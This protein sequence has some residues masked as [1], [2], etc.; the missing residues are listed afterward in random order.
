[1]V[2][3]MN[4]DF[5]SMRYSDDNR[6]REYPSL[7]SV[8]PA[9]GELETPSKSFRNLLRRIFEA[10]PSILHN[11]IDIGHYAVSQTNCILNKSQDTVYSLSVFFNNFAPRSSAPYQSCG[12]T[13]GADMFVQYLTTSPPCQIEAAVRYILGTLDVLAEC[14][15]DRTNEQLGHPEDLPNLSHEDCIHASVPFLA[16]IAHLAYHSKAVAKLF[17]DGNLVVPLKSIWEQ[18]SKEATS[19]RTIIARDTVSSHILLILACLGNHQ[20]V[21]LVSKL[22]DYQPRSWFINQDLLITNVQ[23]CLALKDHSWIDMSE[24]LQAVV[25][26]ATGTE[27]AY[28]SIVLPPG[29]PL[30]G[31]LCLMGYVTSFSELWHYIYSDDNLG[32]KILR[33]IHATRLLRRSLR[34]VLVSLRKSF[35]SISALG[36]SQKP[37]CSLFVTISVVRC[38]FPP[39]ISCNPRRLSTLFLSK[40]GVQKS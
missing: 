7:Q 32:I 34:C 10:K 19:A 16:V 21:T 12:L 27:S 2:G 36:A 33:K 37:W 26:E 35:S 23:L 40:A 5:F 15:Q 18:C 1:M 24:N 13:S 30:S 8:M 22:R 14:W 28:T 9:E 6:D 31:L 20:L 29:P 38:K 25:W 4:L 11:S 3:P 39:P 17:L